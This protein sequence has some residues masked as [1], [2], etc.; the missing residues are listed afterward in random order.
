MSQQRLVNVG[1][2]YI[3]VTKNSKLTNNFI[4]NKDI[5]ELS[6]MIALIINGG[7]KMLG[8]I[9]IIIFVIITFFTFSLILVG[10]NNKSEYERIME[11]KEQM[12][13]IKNYLENKRRK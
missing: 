1:K 13:Y 9:L 11:D 7:M 3:N 2:S 8:I 12:I 4:K 10:C 5:L 6:I